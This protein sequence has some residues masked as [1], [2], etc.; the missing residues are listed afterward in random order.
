MH[1]WLQ[2]QAV[3]ESAQHFCVNAEEKLHSSAL[4][5]LSSL[6]HGRLGGLGKTG[7]PF[8]KWKVIS[9]TTS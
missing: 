7:D 3:T 5:Y 4:A 6:S 8:R 2:H 1:L 9:L